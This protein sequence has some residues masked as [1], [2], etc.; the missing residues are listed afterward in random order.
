MCADRSG[1]TL[2]VTPPP[3]PNGPLHLG[4]LAGPYIAGDVAARA[5]RADGRDVITICGLD[6]HQNYVLARAEA[7]GE[8]PARTIAHYGGLIRQSMTTARIDHDVFLEPST[9][10]AYRDGVAMLLAEAVDRKAVLIE[11]VDLSACG[12]CGRVLHHVRVS[13]RCPRCGSGAAGGTCETCASFL[14]PADL[15]RAVSSCCDAVPVDVRRRVPVLRLEDYRDR[16]A[17]VW[18]LAA[19]PP[20]ARTLVQRQLAE[21]LPDVAV[22]YPTDW[23]IPWSHPTVD[24]DGPADM[25]V[26]VWAEMGLGYLFAVARHLGAPAGNT[27]DCAAAWSEVAELWFFLG[28]DNTFYYSTLIPALLLG[29][30]VGPGVLAGLV[31]NEFYRLDG[32]KFSTSR[33]H[34]VWAHEFLAGEDPGTVRAYLSYDRPDYYEADFTAPRYAAFRAWYD[35]LLT[36]DG[37]TAPPELAELELSRAGHALRLDRFDTALAIRSLLAAGPSRSGAARDLLRRITGEPEGV[38]T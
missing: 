1:R 2:I 29:A 38:R 22:A 8:P 21:G 19:L 18:A 30:G 7:S 37:R 32:A 17:E 36:G 28:V 26:D 5:A 23:G 33:N 20:R 11:E 15:I 13:G 31:V 27:E 34:A 24:V 10:P 12:A 3:T 6:S 14:T 16:L 4:H 35:Q 9:D 25:R